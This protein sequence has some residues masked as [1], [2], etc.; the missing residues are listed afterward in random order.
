MI[1]RPET[2]CASHDAC[3][4]FYRFECFRVGMISAIYGAIRK[5]LVADVRDSRIHNIIVFQ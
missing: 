2:L 1:N 3:Q 4:I 5:H